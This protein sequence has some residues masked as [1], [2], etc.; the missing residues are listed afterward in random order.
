MILPDLGPNKYY[1]E[2]YDAFFNSETDQWLDSQC[3]DLECEYCKD[4]PEKPSQ[5]QN[6]T[7]KIN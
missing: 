4:R 5:I 6:E 3:D 2:R 7:I 1:S